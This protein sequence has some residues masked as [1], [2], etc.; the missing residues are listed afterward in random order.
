MDIRNCKS[1]KGSGNTFQ[2]G[3][4]VAERACVSCDGRG[5]FP[6]I[7]APAIIEAIKGRKGLRSKAPDCYGANHT[8]SNIR[9][10]YVWRMARFHGGVD[11]TMPV[12]AGIMVNGDP[13]TKELDALADAVAKRVFGTDLAA[14]YRWGN[15]L[16]GEIAVPDGM[17]ATAYSCGPVLTAEKPEEEMAELCDESGICDECG[18]EHGT[19]G[20][21]EIRE[22][23]G[24]EA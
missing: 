21:E 9:A 12:V 22:L 17:P 20:C 23:V 10:Y 24:D 2:D 19:N 8:V 3:T 6:E 7:D 14:A 5:T 1:C 13:Y 18:V 16:V 4:V 15:L 11:V